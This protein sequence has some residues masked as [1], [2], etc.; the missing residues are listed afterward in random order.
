MLVGRILD[1]LKAIGIVKIGL[2]MVTDNLEGQE[3]WKKRGW[4]ARTD[5]I[6]LDYDL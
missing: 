3:F 5:V 1:V 4:N 2:L 6:Y